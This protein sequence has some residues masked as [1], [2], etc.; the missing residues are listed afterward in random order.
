[1]VYSLSTH[2]IGSHPGCILSRPMTE[3]CAA[4]N[5]STRRRILRRQKFSKVL[6]RS[7]PARGGR[8]VSRFRDVDDAF[9]R[10][11]DAFK[12]RRFG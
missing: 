4:A 5:F 12:S 6:K 1:M 3:R 11:G 10:G 8:R 2:A 7:P 9:K